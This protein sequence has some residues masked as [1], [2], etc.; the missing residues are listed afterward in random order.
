MC[1]SFPPY[2]DHDAFMHHTM[3][4][5]DAPDNMHNSLS[6]CLTY[7]RLTVMTVFKQ[8]FKRGRASLPFCCRIGRVEWIF[9]LYYFSTSLLQYPLA[10][11][12]VLDQFGQCCKLFTCVQIIKVTRILNLDVCH[13]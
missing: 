2:F 13:L 5:L 8:T 11:C 10:L 9:E 4:I 6:S 3:H 1:F 12:I 7:Y